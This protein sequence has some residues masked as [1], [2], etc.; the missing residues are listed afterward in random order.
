[1]ATVATPANLSIRVVGPLPNLGLLPLLRTIE[2][3]LSGRL[4]YRWRA[5]KRKLTHRYSLRSRRVNYGL[6]HA[7]PPQALTADIFII[8][9]GKQ[10]VF[11][12]AL[13]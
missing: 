13:G 7:K 12:I 3:S 2:G 10:N 6:L 1:M 9:S 4:A 5:L 11:G 8:L